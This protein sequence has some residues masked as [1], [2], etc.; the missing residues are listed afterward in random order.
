MIITTNNEQKPDQFEIRKTGDGKSLF[1]N[2]VIQFCPFQPALILPGQIQGQL[3]IQRTPC[4]THCPHFNIDQD[5]NHFL[6]CK[7][8]KP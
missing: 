1:R 4:G 8:Q 2:D 6:T 7:A 5:G 3:Q